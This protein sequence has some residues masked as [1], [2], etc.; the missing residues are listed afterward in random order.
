MHCEV[1]PEA[2]RCSPGLA[3]CSG[4]RQL[5]VDSNQA[6]KDLVQKTLTLIQYQDLEDAEYNDEY[7][8]SFDGLGGHVGWDGE[9]EA[10]SLVHAGAGS[11]FCCL[12]SIASFADEAPKSDRLKYPVYADTREHSRMQHAEHDQHMHTSDVSGDA[13]R[14]QRGHGS[15]AHAVTGHFGRSNARGGNFKGRG[16]ARP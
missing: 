16:R 4:R 2:S 11:R 9:A 14:A 15:S 3:L 7:D 6:K 12:H 10:E 1:D 13:R 5:D 8:D